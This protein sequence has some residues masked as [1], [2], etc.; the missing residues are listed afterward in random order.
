[1]TI[2]SAILFLVSIVFVFSQMG[3]KLS[4]KD[5]G[6]WWL[7]LVFLLTVSLS[8][9]MLSHVARI[10][11][12][13]L[14]SNFVLS[15]LIF[16]LFAQVYILASQNYTQLQNFRE[17][18]SNLASREYK[19]YSDAS[20]MRVSRVLVVLGC[21][22]E[23]EALP[24]TLK[25]LISLR[26]Q[27]PWIDVCLVND[28][29]TDLTEAVLFSHQES[30]HFVTHSSNIGVSGV[31]LTAFRVQKKFNYDFVV[32]CD[33]DGQHPIEV[34]PDLIKKG[35]LGSY[36][37]LI[38]SRFLDS[39]DS[40]LAGTTPM[41]RI[42]GRVISDCLR[43]F[44]KNARVTDPTSGLRVYSKQA[45]QVLTDFM[46]EEYPE[47]ES[48]ALLS[49]QGLKIGETQVQM[50]ARAGG[51]SSLDFKKSI[52]FMLKVVSSLLATRLRWMFAKRARGVDFSQ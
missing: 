6:T 16:F 15:G 35:R 49:L 4:A 2:T 43:I 1:M 51:V 5:A 12:F 7:V 26:A 8:P 40:K 30:L 45:C 37:L 33:S 44:G 41:R 14:V 3:R 46:P 50:A 13:E 38:G 25:K 47:P 27:H 19:P 39:R 24:E 28:G 36:D 34:I 21:Y 48:I 42:G 18:V 10:F 32:Q 22:N 9:D 23:E 20:T 17:S 31:L 29:S 52:I 11:G